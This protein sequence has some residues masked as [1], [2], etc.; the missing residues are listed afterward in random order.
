M[1]R[2]GIVKLSAVLIRL[3]TSAPGTQQPRSGADV[4]SRRNPDLSDGSTATERLTEY[5]AG[6]SF[7]Y[8]LTGNRFTDPWRSASAR[9][10]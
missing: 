5:T 7:A 3:T 8:E 6:H 4:R 2:G 10:L 9:S 1:M